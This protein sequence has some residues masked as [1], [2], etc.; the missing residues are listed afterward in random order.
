MK[1]SMTLAME[2]ADDF[3]WRLKI[4]MDTAQTSG[5]ILVAKIREIEETG[6]TVPEELHQRMRDQITIREYQLKYL[7]SVATFKTRVTQVLSVAMDPPKDSFLN[8]GKLSDLQK[9]ADLVQHMMQILETEFTKTLGAD[10]LTI[11]DPGMQQEAIKLMSERLA[12]QNTKPFPKEW[13][14]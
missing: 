1:Q 2:F 12:K 14:N 6:G 8:R 13:Q 10:F 4:A 11:T 7:D 9:G 3:L 5:N